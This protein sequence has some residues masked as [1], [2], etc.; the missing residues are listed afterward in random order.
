MNTIVTTHNAQIKA[1]IGELKLLKNNTISELQ[2]G[3]EIVVGDNL[4]LTNNAEITV[5]YSD[6]RIVKLNGDDASKFIARV[7]EN[8]TGEELTLSDELPDEVDEVIGDIDDE[9]SAIQ[10]QIENG[11]EL[12][13]PDTA[14]GTASAGGGISFSTV[15]RT[16]DETLANTSFQSESFTQTADSNDNVESAITF[17]EISSSLQAN[18]TV[19]SLEKT[20][21]ISGTT[22]G[23]IENSSVSITLTDAQGNQV[24]VDNVIIA[25]NGSFTAD[26]VDISSL[27]DGDIIAVFNVIDANNQP[28]ETQSADELD[29]TPPAQP[30]VQLN[31]SNNDG[32]INLA[33]KNVG[34]DASI[35]L[36]DP[37]LE[38]GDI[39]EVVVTIGNTIINSNIPVTQEIINNQSVTVTLDNSLLTND[40]QVTVA[41]TVIDDKGNRSPTAQDS[42]IVDINVPG[43]E[44]NQSGQSVDA[45]SVQINE[46]LDDD[47]IDNSEASNLDARINIPQ[48]GVEVGDSLIISINGTEQPPI[49][50]T[51]EI[52]DAGFTTIIIPPSEIIDGQ[53]IDV[54]AKVTDDAGNSSSEGRDSAQVDLSDPN[55]IIGPISDIDETANTVSENANIGDS[56]GVHAD[57]TDLDGDDITY[58]LSN[59]ADGRFSIDATTGEISVAQELDFDNGDGGAHVVSVVALSTDGSS[60]TNDFTI[61]VTN[62]DGT[63]P[64]QGDTDNAIGPVT[65]IDGA[66]NTVSENASIGDSTGVHADAIDLDGDDITYSLSNNANGR[67][68]INATTGEISVA[69]ELDFENGDGGEHIVTVVALSTD[70]TSS[71]NDFTISVTNA[72]GTTPGQGDTDNAIGPVTDIDG[73]NNTVSEN[74]SIGDS[75]GVH[76]D[77]TDLDG[78]AITY[79]LSDDADARFTIDA[80]TGE[81]SVAREL[82]FEGGDAGSHDVTVVALSTDGSSST[83][84]FT[85]SVTDF[86][87]AATITLTLETDTFREDL[88]NTGD[89][90]A[91]IDANDE[92]DADP[93]L[94]I[95]DNDAGFYELSTNGAGEPIVILTAAG[96]AHVNAGNDL[97]A[98]SVSA[99]GVESNDVDPALDTNEAITLSADQTGITITEDSSVDGT[100][101]AELVA[102][103]PD[104]SAI[105]YT[106]S[107]NAAGLFKIVG[108]EL[109]LTQAGADLVNTGADLPSVEVTAQST[110]GQVSTS[111]TITITPSATVD[112]DDAA[113]ITLT[114]E[115]DTFREDLT[116]TGDLVA[117]I[118]ANDEDDA[119]PTLVINDNDAGFYELSTNGAGEP[120]VILTAAGA[121]HVNAGND[122]PAF[123]VSANG[124]ESNDVDPALDTNEAITLSADQTGITITEDSSVDGTKVAELVANDPDGSAITYTLSDNA[125]GLFKIVGNELQLTQAGANLVSTGAD[126]PSVEVTAQST[127]GQ[128]STSSTITIT[129]SATVDTNDAPNAEDDYGIGLVAGLNGYYYGYTPPSGANLNSLSDVNAVISANNPDA[130]FN[131]QQIYYTRDGGN[132]G[133]SGTLKHS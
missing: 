21:E 108:N 34:V 39:I 85:I 88:T 99:N 30:N 73:A 20:S 13:L 19:N 102:N 89:L 111:S 7:D 116:N 101:V 82:N 80:S 44:T 74:A 68:S 27:T 107:D 97:P 32:F 118:D 91:S 47:I 87:D 123:S 1:I 60:N 115:T 122:L 71:T 51:Q 62:T 66:N 31:D 125:A 94:V 112:V 79:S 83:E 103:D 84:K 81:I 18:F 104:G 37:T 53:S 36:N 59:N 76:A 65:D 119:D 52:I 114:L 117:S 130:T 95:N 113:T 56:T 61:S 15:P 26:N 121:A 5:Q 25:S 92:D 40:T 28:I 105:T 72:N 14:A 48:I 129:P 128:V 16:N 17:V 3:D 120:I 35:S 127:A 10:S 49:E 110:A 58:S 67:F 8:T 86:D 42:S 50:L 96:A 2:V 90:V 75:T 29:T 77:A 22:T 70:G 98:F 11:G 57:A 4:I 45:P 23:V 6:G 33:E 100:K 109:Q 78:D 38:I 93:T 9:I 133:G 12:E 43:G 124:V 55:N 64:G 24:V 131:G 54:V 41:A 63:T 46:L 106:L 69:Q 126:L 132:L